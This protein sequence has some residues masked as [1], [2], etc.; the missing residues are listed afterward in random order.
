MGLSMAAITR[1]DYGNEIESLKIELTYWK[2][3][4][5]EAEKNS[6]CSNQGGQEPQTRRT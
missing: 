3:R 5:I 2:Q 6:C 4:A 1:D